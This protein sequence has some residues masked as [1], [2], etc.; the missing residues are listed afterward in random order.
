MKTG[1]VRTRNRGIVWELRET[2]QRHNL[3]HE[4]AFHIL[5]DN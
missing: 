5:L 4:P 1:K 3:I 2:T